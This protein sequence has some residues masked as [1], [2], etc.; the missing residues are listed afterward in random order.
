[1]YQNIEVDILVND[2]PIKKFSHGGKLFIQANHQTEYSIK[3]RNN[4]WHRRLFVVSVD[5]INVIDGKAAGSTKMGYV[6]NGLSPIEIKG[7]RTDNDTVH[8]FKFSTKRRS[9]AA[10]SD[11]AGG[12]TS[13]CG[14]IGIEVYDE[15]QKPIVYRSFAS[16]PRRPD[17]TWTLNSSTSKG[18]G[19]EL[20]S[21][22]FNSMDSVGDMSFM[23]STSDFAD[24]APV[25]EASFSMG[26]EF[27]ERAVKDSVREVEFE[28]G[29]LLHTISIY[30]GSREDLVKMNVPIVSQ[31]QIASFPQAF[32]SKF[33]KPPRR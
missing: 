26:T 18:L 1:M 23:C 27:S 19:G 16:K 21:R 28:I 2:K 17:V 12:D 13:N 30:Y 3:I 24:S 25:E 11:E 14:V 6:V 5:G 15:Y 32:P 10:K 33:C 20:M 7:F 29:S 22:S 8:P 4:N 9:Y 31:K